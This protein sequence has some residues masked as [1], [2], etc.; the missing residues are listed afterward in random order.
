MMGL[1]ALYRGRFAPSPTGL[2]H[3]GT[4]RT[5]LL[6][7]QRARWAGGKFILRIED[8][9]SPRVVVGA[10]ADLLRDLSW[11]GL[12][13]DEGPDVG[14]PFGPYVQSQRLGSYQD[15]LD[16]LKA[17][18]LV[19]PCT[20]T[21]KEIAGIASA[22]HGNEGPAYPGLCREKPCHPGRPAAW[23][24]NVGNDPA[25]DFVVQRADGVFSYQLA[26][27]VDDAAMGITEVVRGEDLKGSESWQ[28][29]LL[30]ALGHV[31]PKYLHTPLMLG[32][33]GQRLS[34]RHGSIA[35]A[36]LREAGRT[37]ES[38]VTELLEDVSGWPGLAD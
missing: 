1:M 13:W 15:A 27:A 12:D 14:G 21:R 20:C 17:K 38:L 29:A 9:D 19:Y 8:L 26:C 23:R 18:G 25:G 35:I 3:L 16:A 33:D 24:F 5:A 11:L 32:P 28:R 30:E 6:A 37:P 36:E 10:E 31:P 4:A 34:K 22:P 7:W 2:L